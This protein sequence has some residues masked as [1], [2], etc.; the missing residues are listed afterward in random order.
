M[1]R[2]YDENLQMDGLTRS[3]MNV[4][5]EQYMENADENE[6][7]RCIHYL[8]NALRQPMMQDLL[9]SE[10]YRHAN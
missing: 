10:L 8:V 6:P 1:R 2:E 9:R 3:F 4:L 5:N 7:K